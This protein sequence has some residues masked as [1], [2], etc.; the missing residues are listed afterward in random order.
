MTVLGLHHV[1][2]AARSLS[3]TIKAL[4]I[5]MSFLGLSVLANRG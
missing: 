1:V 5:H 3:T 2:E 4:F